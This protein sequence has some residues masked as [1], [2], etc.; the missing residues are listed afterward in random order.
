[1]TCEA[2]LIG[3]LAGLALT[4]AVLSSQALTDRKAP[5]RKT[6]RLK[7]EERLITDTIAV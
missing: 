6:A 2:L 7:E 4:A 3:S 5:A 1:M